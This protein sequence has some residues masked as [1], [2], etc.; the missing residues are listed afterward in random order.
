MAASRDKFTKLNRIT[1]K[2]QTEMRREFMEEAESGEAS[3]KGMTRIGVGVEHGMWDAVLPRFDL[4]RG[5]MGLAVGNEGGL[6]GMRLRVEVV[7]RCP[8]IE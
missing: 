7:W 8:W 2:R 4:W 3:V 6:I 5:R 1:A